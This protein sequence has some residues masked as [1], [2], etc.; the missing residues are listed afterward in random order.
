MI[1]I[2]LLLLY[3]IKINLLK[4]KNLTWYRAFNFEDVSWISTSIL[5][6]GFDHLIWKPIDV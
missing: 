6:L 1:W 2:L 4:K 5:E 3:N